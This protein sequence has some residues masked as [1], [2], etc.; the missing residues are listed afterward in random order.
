MTLV[1]AKHVYF[2]GAGKC[3][4]S[5]YYFWN[6]GCGMSTMR[7]ST[8][9]T[10]T[11]TRTH[12]TT[13]THMYTHMHTQGHQDWVFQACWLDDENFVTAGR[14]AK[15]IS[16]HVNLDDPNLLTD[17]K[18]T[19]TKLTR[20]VG[21]L[22]RDIHN[23]RSAFH[24]KT[25]LLFW[26]LCVCFVC[27]CFLRVCVRVCVC[28]RA[29]VLCKNAQADK[30]A[31]SLTQENSGSARA[32]AAS[33]RRALCSAVLCCAVL[34]CACMI[35]LCCA[36]CVCVCV[37]ALAGSCVAHCPVCVQRAVLCMHGIILLTTL[38]GSCVAH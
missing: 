22:Q 36:V 17:V 7:Y 12:T 13:R 23:T 27:V 33:S 30:C 3:G 1:R 6:L 4:V 9:L 8:Q 16:W 32:S 38:A 11:H 35:A 14:D 19:F 18:P 10:H 24:V 31:A 5:L 21:G 29:R 20:T 15:L 34:C 28:V 37:T 26:L 25:S 2:W